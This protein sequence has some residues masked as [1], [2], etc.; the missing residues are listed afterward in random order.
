MS[1]WHFT[2][3]HSKISVLPRSHPIQPLIGLIARNIDAQI[4]QNYL[5]VGIVLDVGLN[6]ISSQSP[7]FWAAPFI[8]LN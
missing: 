8:F 5:I 6:E 7:E 1:Y 2:E 4:L 3:V